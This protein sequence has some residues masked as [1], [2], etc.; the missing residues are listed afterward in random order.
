MFGHF[1]KNLHLV[2]LSHFSSMFWI[3]GTY[4]VYNQPLSHLW[5][6]FF[7]LW[8]VVELSYFPASFENKNCIYRHQLIILAIID[9]CFTATR[10]FLFLNPFCTLSECFQ[11][12]FSFSG[13]MILQ[14]ILKIFS[15]INICKNRSPNC[16]PCTH[17]PGAMILTNMLT[18]LTFW[19]IIY[20]F[21][22]RWRIFHLYGDV[23]IAGEGL[24]NLG[25]CSALGALSRRHCR[26]TG[27]QML[28][29]VDQ[30][31]SFISFVFR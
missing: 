24:Q 17:L 27:P 11:V 19:L 26:D 31:F 29:T 1:L 15:Y 21:T 2:E 6:T 13:P 28:K 25:L 23:T 30:T 12:N 14:N 9:K 10:P 3:D 5:L 4:F 8:T 16:S 20:C 7:K 22:S 18:V